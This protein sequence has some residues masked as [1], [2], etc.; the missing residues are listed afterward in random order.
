MDKRFSRTATLYTILFLGMLVF[1]VVA[2]FYGMNIGTNRVE[3]KYA[4]LNEEKVDKTNYV[5]QQQE[6]A[7]FYLTVYSPYREFQL[8][9]S[10]AL[11]NISNK[12]VSNVSSL[13]K[14]LEGQA[15][16]KAIEAAS[17]NLQNAGQLGEAQQNYI[18]SLNQFEKVAATLQKKSSSITYEQIIELLK[19]NESYQTAVSQALKGQDIYFETMNLWAI[20]IDPNIPTD[21]DENV[22]QKISTWSKYPLV[23]KNEIIAN[24]L[25]EQND[26]V[27]FLPH[28]LTSAID[29]FITSGQA[30]AMNLTTIDGIITLLLNTSAVRPGDYNLNKNKLYSQEFLPQIPFFYPNVE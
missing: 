5:Y 3:A 14:E 25:A 7:S 8:D 6:L 15:S 13:Y 19:S 12:K 20:S 10:E 4:H 23:I 1:A 16:K 29:Q 24:Y 26:F 30:E 18:R 27:E 2:F 21:F 22:S 28:D 17:Y 9:W 11:H